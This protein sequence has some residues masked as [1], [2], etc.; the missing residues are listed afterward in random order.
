[1]NKIIQF[2]ITKEGEDRLAYQRWYQILL[3]PMHIVKGCYYDYSTKQIFYF[4]KGIVLDRLYE[5]RLK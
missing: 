4:C 3:I 1:M 2:P 5:K